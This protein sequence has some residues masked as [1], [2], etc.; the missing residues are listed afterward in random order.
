MEEDK[1]SAMDDREIVIAVKPNREAT[2]DEF[3]E[4][5]MMTFT[6]RFLY[7]VDVTK[8][9]TLLYSEKTIESARTVIN[10][11][12]RTGIMCGSDSDMWRAYKVYNSAIHPTSEE[13][14]NPLFRV[15]AIAPVNIPI[16]FGMLL[17][18]PTNVLGTMA[19][20]WINQSYNSA[21]NYANRAGDAQPVEQIAVSY[22]LAVSSACAFAYGLGRIKVIGNR[23]V[24]AILT[25]VYI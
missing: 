16:V 20:H 21:C 14:I 23:S 15:S 25:H 7:F 13:I 18:P 19:L 9:S 1:S 12:K 11:Y 2:M 17:C 4:S 6:G 22:S 24:N 10:E 5:K 3:V 8:P